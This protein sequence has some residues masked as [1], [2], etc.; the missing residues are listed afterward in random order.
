MDIHPLKTEAD[1]EAALEQ[2]DRLWGSPEGTPDGDHLDV[3]LVLVEHYESK[4][5]RIDLP[6]PIDAIKFRMEQMNLTRKDLEPLIGSRGRVSEVFNRRRSLSLPM[7]RRLHNS[8]HIPL[9]CLVH[10]T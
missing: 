7:I 10:E 4:H 9:E 8:L 5:H 1:Y 2:I 6:D 3:L